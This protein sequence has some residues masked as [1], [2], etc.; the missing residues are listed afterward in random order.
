MTLK[1]IQIPIQYGEGGG[2]HGIV[3]ASFK[4]KIDLCL[5]SFN[6]NFFFINFRDQFVQ[7]S[8]CE[9]K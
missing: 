7:N 6:F 9:F 4:K 5:V 8:L 3:N 2:G 1:E